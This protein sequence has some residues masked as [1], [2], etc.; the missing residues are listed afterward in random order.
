MKLNSKPQSA[1]I[2]VLNS[3]YLPLNICNLKRGY[4][5]LFKGKAEIISVDENNPIL[6]GGNKV[7]DRPSVIRILKYVTVPYKKIPITRYNV[8]KRDGYKCAY[9]FSTKELTLDHIY[10]RS[11]GGKNSWDNLITCCSPCNAQKNDR[12]PE[13]ASMEL[14]I[15]PFTPGHLFFLI[16]GN[17]R[18][19]WKQFI[20]LNKD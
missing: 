5:L 4:K 15:K 3:D 18:E 8:F 7:Y 14:K 20:F 11:R 16:S 9:C 12:T 19:D 10:P 6:S 13:E 2:L 1:N 17:I